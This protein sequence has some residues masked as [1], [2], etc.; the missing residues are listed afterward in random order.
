MQV[1]IMYCQA[2]N[3]SRSGFFKLNKIIDDKRIHNFRKTMERHYRKKIY[4]GVGDVDSI[5][6]PPGMKPLN[7]LA[8][9]R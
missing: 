1:K 6:E 9:H 4:F 2:I 7:F 8:K 3:G 5:Y